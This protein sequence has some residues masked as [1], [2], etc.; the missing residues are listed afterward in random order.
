MG[1][2]GDHLAWAFQVPAFSAKYRVISFD[3]RGAGQSSVPDVPYS[4]GM[5]ADD[6]VGLL[7]ALGVER[8]HVLGVSMGGMIA[9]EIALSHPRR[10]RSLQLHCTYARP[11]RYMLALMDAWRSVRSKATPEEWLRTV[12]LWLFA[13][14]TF[15]ERPDFVETVIQTGLASPHPFTLTGFFRQGDAVRG[16]DALTRLSGLTCPT[17]VSVA[18]DDIL[19][20]P[21]FSREIA[22][23]VPKAELRVIERA[24][25]A[26]FWERFDVF[27]SM[28]LEFLAR[29]AAA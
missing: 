1:F 10:V 27:N 23:A 22:A 15:V 2:G 19:V 3:N 9:Q 17:L 14:V 20:P 21:R 7:D 28:C 5:M 11:D 18:E 6:A 13:P 12:A 8:A 4:T 25:H 29:H 24:G 16:H 26:Y